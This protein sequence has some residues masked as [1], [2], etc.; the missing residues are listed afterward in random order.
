MSNKLNPNTDPNQ[1]RVYQIRI[2]GHL[3]CQWKDWF[4]DVSLFLYGSSQASVAVMGVPETGATV[5]DLTEAKK[6]QTVSSGGGACSTIANV[7]ALKCCPKSPDFGGKIRGFCSPPNNFLA[8]PNVV[9]GYD[10]D[11]GCIITQSQNDP[12]FKY[13][14]ARQAGE[15]P[16]FPDDS[17][18][19]T[20]LRSESGKYFL[21][22]VNYFMG[23]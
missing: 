9:E 12:L 2:E 23:V 14:C 1:P 13:V 16:F 4:Q 3:G 15:M 20:T 8:H 6:I 22:K 19:K 10:V 17:L 21:K 11:I 7:G 5:V 18:G